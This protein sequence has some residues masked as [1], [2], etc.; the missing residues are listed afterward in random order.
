[1]WQ[2]SHDG[3]GGFVIRRGMGGCC[4][5]SVMRMM[6]GREMRKLEKFEVM[7]GSRRRRKRADTVESYSRRCRQ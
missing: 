2:T 3:D 4:G 6:A 5:V 7:E 1:M